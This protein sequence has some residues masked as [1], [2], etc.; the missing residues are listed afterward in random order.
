MPMGTGSV[1]GVYFPV[2][3]ALCRLVNQHRREHGLRCAARPPRAR[4]P[5]SA[6]LRDGARRPRHRAVRH[7]GR[8]AATARAASPRPAP[9]AELRAVMALLSRAADRR[10]PRRR[11]HRRARGSR[12]QAGGARRRRLG[13]ARARRRA[14]GRARLDAGELRRDARARADRPAGAL[15]DGEIDAFFFAVGHPALAIQEATTGCDAVLVDGARAGGRR[16]WSPPTPCFFAATIPGG[17]YRGNPAPVA[18]L[19]RRRH[20]R[21]PRRRAGGRDRTR[22]V[23]RDLRG[24]RDA[25]RPR[26]GAGRPRARG[27]GRGR[28]DGAA[29]PRRRRATSASAAGSNSA[30]R[31]ASAGRRSPRTV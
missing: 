10:R 29:A 28:P 2:G 18:D 27:D 3:V 25:A 31:I 22:V 7:P 20:A 26:P 8:R 16:R 13:H 24:L 5:T 30:A 11:R 4:S 23:Q 12:R 19:R 14:D 17:L 9:F 15:C 21:H 1:T 6:G